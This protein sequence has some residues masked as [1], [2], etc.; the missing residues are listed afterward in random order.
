M[1]YM[2]DFGPYNDEFR[3]DQF[4]LDPDYDAVYT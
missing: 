1:F 3:N 2:G 4:P